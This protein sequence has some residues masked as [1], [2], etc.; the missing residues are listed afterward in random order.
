VQ[1][2]SKAD[3]MCLVFRV[4][5]ALLSGLGCLRCYRVLVRS[6]SPSHLAMLSPSP[7]ASTI[8]DVRGEPGYK[9]II[10]T[11]TVIAAQTLLEH[12]LQS[13]KNTLEKRGARNEYGKKQRENLKNR[14]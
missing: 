14:K 6:V 1:S 13:L 2:L 3:A 8:A 12:S 5:K 7:L 4:P 9:V 11:V 10:H